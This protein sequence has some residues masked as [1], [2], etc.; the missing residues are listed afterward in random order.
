MD[1]WLKLKQRE[2]MKVFCKKNHK[3]ELNTAYITLGM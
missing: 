1:I 3:W 2:I